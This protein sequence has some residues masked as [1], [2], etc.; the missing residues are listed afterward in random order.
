MTVAFGLPALAALVTF[1]VLRRL[2]VKWRA[3]SS[4]GRGVRVYDLGADVALPSRS[5]QLA[6]YLTMKSRPP[7]HPASSH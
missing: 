3:A 4:R 7:E 1:L 2:R 5:Y 6:L